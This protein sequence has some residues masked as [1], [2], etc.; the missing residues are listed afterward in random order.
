[1]A[2]LELILPLSAQ[3]MH[4]RPLIAEHIRT[5]R[6]EPRFALNEARKFSPETRKDWMEVNIKIVRSPPLGLLLTF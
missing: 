1:M 2:S 5:G 4:H 6:S 3:F